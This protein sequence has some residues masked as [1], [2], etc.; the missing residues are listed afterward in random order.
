MD[1]TQQLQEMRDSKMSP[2]SHES[3]CRARFHGDSVK[4]SGGQY[5]ASP[6]TTLGVGPLRTCLMSLETPCKPTFRVCCSFPTLESHLFAARD[7]EGADGR[8]PGA[9]VGDEGDNREAALGRG[10][11]GAPHREE[12]HWTRQH[13]RNGQMLTNQRAVFSRLRVNRFGASRVHRCTE[14]CDVTG[15]C[16]EEE[17]TCAGWPWRCRALACASVI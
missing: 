5:D 4:K 7:A 2:V 15:K 14:Q 1:F 16:L 3:K 12:S 10:Q 11:R 13:E 9:T 17:D 8:D 6:C